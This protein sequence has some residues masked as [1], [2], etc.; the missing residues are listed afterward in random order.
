MVTYEEIAEYA[1]MAFVV[2]AVI[3]GLAVGYMAY[4]ARA[5]VP[6]AWEN[7]DVADINGYVMLVMLIL[8]VIVGLVSITAKEVRPFLIATIALMIAG[9]ANVWGPLGKVHEALDYLAT[10]VLNYIVAFAAPAAVILAI[11]SIWELA[12]KK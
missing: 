9:T 1:F 2:I 10:G 12:R 4:D 6:A 3:A 5:K 11:K 8:G 7:P